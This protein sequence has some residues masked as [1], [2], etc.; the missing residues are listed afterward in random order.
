VKQLELRHY[1][2][3]LIDEAVRRM[4]S[5]GFFGQGLFVGLGLGKTIM[6]IEIFK[7]LEATN[8]VKRALVLAPP[9]VC[10]LTWPDEIDRWVDYQH[11]SYTNLS[12]KTPAKRKEYL[13]ERADV[14]ISTT[15]SV[16]WLAKEF[17]TPA[18]LKRLPYDFL[19]VDESTAYKTW[20]SQRSKALRKILPR[21][22]RSL[23]LTATPRP[24]S[25]LDLF[26]QM[27]LLDKGDTFGKSVTRFKSRFGYQGGF[28][29]Y[30][31]TPF[32]D[33]DEKVNEEIA[34][35]IIR[36]DT[37][38]EIDMPQLVFNN[39]EVDLTPTV[40]SMYKQLE[41]E[42]WLELSDTESITPVNAGVRYMACKQ[43]TGGAVYKTTPSD[44]LGELPTREA[45]RVHDAKLDLLMET[46]EAL[47]APALVAYQYQW[48]HDAIMARL[49]DK[50]LVESINGQ[51][52][53][54]DAAIA[55]KNWNAGK[56]DVLLCQPQGVS[57]GVNLQYG[58]GRD[59]IWYGLTDLPEVYQQFN[60]RIYRPGVT[61]GVTVHHLLVKSTVEQSIAARLAD[62]AAGEKGMLDYL[63]DEYQQRIRTNPKKRVK[64]R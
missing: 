43:F 35:H 27:F 25:V 38:D 1:Q 7:H 52:K 3:S 59:I 44:T 32:I 28:K 53:S 19:I 41:D 2:D 26:S 64:K 17:N 37:A 33:A 10:E 21:F 40:R 11:V 23:I 39:I 5:G 34:P 61:S 49:Q 6:A 16:V 54:K 20:G 46:L 31:W 15:D 29:G 60:G 51:T 12:G 30:V 42:M 8:V 24:N 45:A 58:P 22:K 62:K 36:L 4:T 47:Q 56:L 13:M 57:H 48:E 55:V 14:C 50:L 9:R 18:K 63:R